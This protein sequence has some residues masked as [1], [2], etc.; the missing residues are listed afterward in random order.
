MK[1]VFFLLLT[2]YQVNCFSQNVKDSVFIKIADSSV[3]Q[4]VRLGF[5]V[6][7]IPA[8]K[9]L[10][11][12]PSN[13][14]RPS[15]AKELV[16]TLGSFRSEG[17]FIIPKNLAVEIAP[18]LLI[19]PWYTLNQY[20]KNGLLR[21]FTKTRLS[22]GTSED[23]KVK[24]SYLSL[25]LR[26]ALIDKADFRN[27][28][29]LLKDSLYPLQD[30]FI[31]NINKKL[32]LFIQKIGGPEKYDSSFS[33][34]QQDSI[35]NII[36][37][38]VKK[39]TKIDFDKSYNKLI[40]NFKKRNW[41][42]AKLDFAYS[43]VLQ[44]PDSLLGNAKV[45]KNYFW[46]AYATR[47][48]KNNNWGQFLFN[49]SNAFFNSNDKIYNEFTGNFRFYVGANKVKGFI[50]C[51]YQNIDSPSKARLE[52]LY[53]QVGLEASIFKGVWLHFGTGVLNGLNGN[54]KS[55]LLSNLNLYLT[56]PE[57]FKLF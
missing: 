46:L 32:A 13:I 12:D 24:T 1:K 6:P 3:L 37:D 18:A 5:A 56:L 41:N 49:I 48:G 51:Q 45:N 23:K 9:A 11:L 50:E 4:K 57:D 19:N 26:T 30:T 22:L 52:T 10:G 28:R 39:E 42:A 40:E 43:L 53:A 8:F 17:D 47:P 29:S 38:Q 14:L 20:Q 2:I 25:G 31:A 16:L 7:D 44:S 27:D 35:L 54:N 55:Q 15:E 36:K 33:K 34:S 21:A